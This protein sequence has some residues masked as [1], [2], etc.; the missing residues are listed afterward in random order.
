MKSA[1]TKQSGFTLIELI[2]VI[3]MLGVLSVTA[4]P[5]FVDLTGEANA[6]VLKSMAGTLKS[7]AN[8]AHTKAIIAR[9]NGGFNNGFDFD[10]VYFDRGYPLG[11][12]YGDGDGIPEILELV[13]YGSSDFTIAENFNGQSAN[14]ELTR[15][16]YIT[17]RN[18][19][20]TGADHAQ[21]AATQCYISYES[22]V[23][24]YREPEIIVDLTGC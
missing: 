5:R 8:I 4:L 18:R 16:V 22:F 24:V 10:G 23:D 6:A 14:G 17:T 20:N 3:I 1:M 7:T 12:S 19:M 11:G 2:L 13:N 21:I 9:R 15:E